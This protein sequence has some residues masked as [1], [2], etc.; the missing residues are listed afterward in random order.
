MQIFKQVKHWGCRGG[1]MNVE[2]QN[3]MKI[4]SLHLECGGAISQQG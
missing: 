3:H 2:G 1:D 4:S